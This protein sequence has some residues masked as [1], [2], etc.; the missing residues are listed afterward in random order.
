MQLEQ[1]GL[2][3]LPYPGALQDLLLAPSTAQILDEFLNGTSWKLPE[4][5]TFLA[6][7]AGG[8]GLTWHQVYA[9][10]DAVLS[11]LSQ[12]MEVRVTPLWVGWP[13]V[14]PCPL[15]PTCPPT[16]CLPG[17]DRSSGHRRAAGSPG[18]GA[19]GGAAVLG[20]GGL[21]APHQCHSPRTATPRP[22]QDP[23]GH[24]RCHEDQQ[25][26]GQ[27]GGCPPCLSPWLTKQ[28]VLVARGS[29]VPAPCSAPRFWDPGPAAD[30]FS[31]LRYIWGG[32]VY[33]Q[34][35]VEQA[36]V[37]VQTGAAPRTG[38]YVQQMP[39]PCYVDDV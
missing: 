22:L 4:L 21:P 17:Q 7:P 26:Q 28:P 13:P 38:V 3:G 30:P 1:G 10:V 23:H 14:P 31:D 25:D 2:R 35:L 32:F 16:V 15:S 34:D 12:F 29:L 37:R 5:A 18:P 19:A 27:V 20:S 33:I 39:Y 8:P 9:D 6:G 11:T 24:R 36:V